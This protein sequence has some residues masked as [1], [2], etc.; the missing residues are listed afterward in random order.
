MPGAD[1]SHEPEHV[2]LY[3]GDCGLCHRTVRW[4]L[5]ADPHGVFHFAPLQGTTAAALRVR[6]P[7]LPADLDT[8]LY[9]DRSTGS[10]QVFLRSEAIFRVCDR[11]GRTSGWLDA[12]RRLPRWLTDLPYRAIARSRH[13]LSRRP[14]PC[15]LPPPAARVRF[16]P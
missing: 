3:D 13:V 10:E 5:A 14:A 11:L 9:V 8:V 1:A 4:I 6:H 16:L 15:P 2:V 12:V 7:E